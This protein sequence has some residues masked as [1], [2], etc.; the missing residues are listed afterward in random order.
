MRRLS[1]AI[2]LC[3]PAFASGAAPTPEGRWEGL[4]QVPGRDLSLIV[5]LKPDSSGRWTGSMIIPGLGIKGAPLSELGVSDTDVQF[6]AG[7]LLAGPSGPATFKAHLVAAGAM[8]GEMKQAGNVASFSLRKVGPAQVE[9]PPR[10]TAVARELEDE[11][12]GEFELGG[13]PRHVTV[14][15]ENHADAAATARFVVAGKKTN[16]LPVD[17]VIQ[18]GAL[19]RIES[20]AT[21]INYEG[22]FFKESSE[23]RGSI[24]LGSME[25]PLTLRRAPA[26]SK[27]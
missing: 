11:W 4:I 2:A 16:D 27:S 19:L 25:L 21:Q 18:E 23:I 22:R 3:F 13:Y 5:D 9:S 26:G 24:E 15:L 1:I 6:G 12:R 10:S 8:A 20:Q 17:L 14:T 7:T